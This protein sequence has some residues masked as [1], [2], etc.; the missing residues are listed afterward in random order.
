MTMAL[1]PP[2]APSTATA[3]PLHLWMQI[4]L[5]L[6]LF[7]VVALLP[8]MPLFSDPRHYL[9]L[10]IALEFLSIIVSLMIFTMGWFSFSHEQGARF[11]LLAC[12]FLGVG[13]LDFVHTLS[14]L[15]MPDLVTPSSAEKAINFW[16]PAR[17]L[18]A[19]ALLILAA[20]PAT[21]TLNPWR[22]GWALVATLVMVS[23]I[24]IMGLFFPHT[25]PH[26]FI[27]GEGLTTFKVAFE[28]GVITLYG[29]AL[30]L[31]FRS[32]RQERDAF[33]A[34][35]ITGLWM[36]LL[37]ELSLTLYAHVT[38]LHNL[39]GHLGKAWG[40]V[41]IFWAVYTQ[42]ME[43]PYQ[44][45]KQSLATLKVVS[46]TLHQSE[47]RHRSALAALVEGV[48]VYNHEGQL[49]T[50][51]PA[52]ERIL[53][54]S[55]A[56]CWERPIDDPR[57]QIVQG[58][59]ALF[60]SDEYP[61]VVTLRTGV[62]QR[63]VLMGIHTPQHELTWIS[64]NSE[65][66]WDANARTVQA[67][68]VSFSDITAR[69]AVEDALHESETRF[70]TIFNAVSDAIFIHDVETGRILDANDTMYAMYGYPRADTVTFDLNDLIAGMPPYSAAEALEKIRLAHTQEPQ[71]FEWQARAHDGHLFWVEVSLRAALI[72]NHPRVLGV[73]RDISERK[74][75]E[76]QIEERQNLIRSMIEGCPETLLLIDTVG[77]ILMLNQTAAQRLG[78]TPEQ[79][80]GT[81]IYDHFPAGVAAYRHTEIAAVVATGQPTRFA[82]Q[83]DQ[84]HFINYL[85]PVFGPE[86]RVSR[87][88]CFGEDVTELINRQQALQAAHTEIEAI[89]QALQTANTA[90]S[91]FLAHMSHEIRTP[92]N[93]V[94][95]LAQLLDRESLNDQQQGLVARI[96]DAG[97]SLLGILND[98]LDLSK[99]E[100]GQLH[101]E[102]RPFALETLLARL[103]SLMGHT[104]R[105]KGI[106]LRIEDRAA[107]SGPLMGDALRLEQ[108]LINLIGNAIKFTEQ[109]A[110]TLE[111]QRGKTHRMKVW[112]RFVVGDTG[113]GIAPETLDR[114]FTPFTQADAGITRRFGGTGLGLSIC[115]RLVEFMGGSIG[116]DSQVGQGSTFWFEL[117]FTSASDRQIAAIASPPSVESTRPASGL[118]LKG[119]HF[120]VVDDSAINRELVERALAFEG[121]TATLA[122]DGQQAVQY[123][124]SQPQ[125]FDAV[126]ID[127]R[128]PVMDGLTATRLIR[129]ELGLTALPILALTAGVLHEQQAAART[130]GVNDVLAKPLDLEQLV[131][132]LLKWVNP[133]PKV[134]EAAA[135]QSPHHNLSRP[136][137]QPFAGADGSKT[138]DEFPEIP[139]IDRV[140]AAQI[141]GQNRAFF[142]RLL[143]GFIDQFTDAVA[144]THRDLTQGDREAAIHRLH[145][146]RGNAGHLG[147]LDLMRA[148]GE[149]EQA[150]ERG[151]TD[152]ETWLA[153]FN[154]QLTAL[155]AASL[156][157]R[158]SA[159]IVAEPACSPPPPLDANQL[160]ALYK[161]LNYND[162]K[163][164]RL[165]KELQPALMAALGNTAAGSLGRA[166]RN[167]RFDEAL[168]IL[169]RT[170][171]GTE[172]DQ[173]D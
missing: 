161:A 84:F 160:A 33:R 43:Q 49:M 173:P 41:F 13:L 65:P 162:L 148:A 121:A 117:P 135:F 101:I 40:A 142:L 19:L 125:A 128:M 169:E 172:A 52:A 119:K 62:P 102:S 154:H 89:N 4:G 3:F 28:Y 77:H 163:A 133:A 140:R 14:Y 54:I 72:D 116:A 141:L 156:P 37:G 25:A 48:T 27:P 93:A 110:V 71:T 5:A 50:V 170:N 63:E 134:A 113:I 57:W 6:G 171:T 15:G 158:G 95:G 127:V 74:H 47:E 21:V 45:L 68:V 59:G 137:V 138:I 105:A 17:L 100:A 146:L 123:L 97:Q 83:R 29:V 75:Y 42:A 64:V 152:I 78:K 39:F 58:D 12:A 126:L 66:V 38:D 35:L 18:S 69:K 31:L 2:D 61:V 151:E 23:V 167:L 109:G 106:D 166:I 56:E 60:P 99:I 85:E 103:D 131:A 8:P 30:L 22:R 92:L 165:F 26:T 53:G 130:A 122:A 16:L 164:L 1:R 118:R 34:W 144:L 67:V 51:N 147:A 7:I 115:K 136:E 104:A 82:D 111:I 153:A 168:A 20:L 11:Q 87:V 10:H 70:R 55:A 124:Q 73:V 90:K 80:I 36:L 24:T 76:F 114:L 9:P 159:T 91:E 132:L 143:T 98:I 155:S 88:L 150:I 96:R 145:T 120:L 79:M 86:G 46:D 108:V 139:G 107:Y 32:W 129:N 149:L 81:V 157:W 112:L 94:L 44:R